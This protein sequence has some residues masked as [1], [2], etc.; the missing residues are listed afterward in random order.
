MGGSNRW[1]PSAAHRRAA[2][3]PATTSP[4]TSRWVTAHEHGVRHGGAA[5]CGGCQGAGVSMVAVLMQWKSGWTNGSG[6]ALKS[7]RCGWVDSLSL[8]PQ[9]GNV[10]AVESLTP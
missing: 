1:D 7:K 5:V 4:D 9:G 6:R 10:E 3:S 8:S 2:A